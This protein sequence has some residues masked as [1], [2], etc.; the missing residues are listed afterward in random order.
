MT[1][2]DNI[3]KLEDDIGKCAKC[4]LC[5]SVCPIFLELGKES[6]VARGKIAL[7]EALSEGKIKASLNL[8]EKIQCCLLCRTCVENCPSSVRVDHIIYKSRVITADTRGVLSVKLLLLKAFLR[9]QR[10]LNISINIAST[11]QKLLFKQT[12]LNNT[13]RP[14]LNIG[15]NRRR[16]VLPLASKPLR[17]QWPECNLSYKS[18]RKVVLFTGCII[19]YVLTKTGDSV[20]KVLMEHGV[21]VVIP[22]D[23]SCC[24]IIAM[25]SGDE[26]TFKKLA[27]NNLK[28][29]AN[30]SAD[31]II[32]ACATCANTLKY[33]YLSLLFNEPDEFHDMAEKVAGKTYDICEYLINILGVRNLPQKKFKSPLKKAIA[34]Y[35]DP[36]HQRRGQ[37]G[38]AEQ[39][40]LINTIDYVRLKEMP[41]RCCGGGGSFNLSYYNLSLKIAEKRIADI[42]ETGADIVLTNCSGCYLQLIDILAQRSS[43]IKV[44]HPVDL[45]YEALN[46]V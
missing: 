8:A 36:C 5:Q 35:H 41:A 15:L 2:L 27:K 16:V 1:A 9:Y 44:K 4:G 43:S 23:Q 20:I 32:V 31:A 24:G 12:G 6:S 33:Q 42:E 3:K 37:R 13:R 28:L 10:L 7:V 39:R 17:D 11:F 45:Y 26:T 19:N 25:A 34:T 40:E 38:Y 21:D 14:R 30:L 29:L 18:K 22:K 46:T